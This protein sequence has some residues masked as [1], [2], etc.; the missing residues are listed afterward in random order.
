[1]VKQTEMKSLSMGIQME[2]SENKK[3]MEK[4]R[5]EQGYM[6]ELAQKIVVLQQS[7]DEIIEELRATQKGIQG[8]MESLV[9]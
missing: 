2:L 4:M 3:E 9:A 1:M 6:K 5:Q 7:K 8:T